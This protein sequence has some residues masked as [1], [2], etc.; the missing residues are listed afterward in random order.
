MKR[1]KWGTKL[2]H[3]V[4]FLLV[5]LFINFF[6]LLNIET[7]SLIGSKIARFFCLLLPENRV[8]KK[9]LELCNIGYSDN[10][11]PKIWEHFG[12]MIGEMPHW[13]KMS[14]E[15]FFRRVKVVNHN[16]DFPKQGVLVS[17]H[18][19]NWELISRIAYEYSVDLSLVHRPA[20]NPYVNRLI[21]DTR[22]YDNVSLIPKGIEGVRQ[23]LKDIKKNHL[24]GMLTDQKSAEG[25]ESVFFNYIAMTTAL[26]A[27]LAL[28]HNV[29]IYP[30]KM[31]RTHGVNYSV[32]IFKPLRINQD[33]S[34]ESITQKI[35]K[36]FETWIK[37]NP[38]Q[39][40]WFHNR[41]K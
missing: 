6:S 7:A 12:E 36:I 28:K 15:E 10:L 40:F 19:G 33:D 24:I 35:N 31:I 17:A 23:I 38:E 16:K 39:W 9:N 27:S 26:P 13:K 11:I 4:E 29:P 2:K 25:V 22:G 37:K 21:N 18:I 20:N 8:I 14:R 5:K 41:W 3:L 34:K 30:I 32:E 1:N